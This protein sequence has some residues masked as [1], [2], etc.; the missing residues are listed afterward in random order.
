MAFVYRLFKDQLKSSSVTQCGTV[1]TEKKH[2][3]KKVW[4]KRQFLIPDVK[5]EKNEPLSASEKIILPPL[6][7]KLG[8]MKNFVKAMDCGGSGFQYLRLKFPKIPMKD[9]ATSLHM[10]LYLLNDSYNDARLFREYNYS[11]K[12]RTFIKNYLPV[13]KCYSE[14]LHLYRSRSKL[15]TKKLNFDDEWKGLFSHIF[16]DQRNIEPFF[17]AY[18][19][20]VLV[21][22][23]SPYVPIEIGDLH[24]VIPG[25][26]YDIYVQ[27]ASIYCL[28]FISYY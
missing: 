26:K 28:F 5:N 18:E 14:N 17:P 8:L 1:G 22:I 20:Q 21:G 19:P 6:H 10:Q 7:I 11:S 4:S 3:I 25:T 15:K 16:L 12:V 23:H 2:Y 24:A 27:L 9:L 13:L